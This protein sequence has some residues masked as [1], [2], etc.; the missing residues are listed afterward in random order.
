MSVAPKFRP[1]AA[2]GRPGEGPVSGSFEVVEHRRL[3][4]YRLLSLSAPEIATRARPGQFVQIAVA[5]PGTL[6]RRPFSIAAAADGGTVTVV[7]DVH[8]PGTEWLAGV[9]L[10]DHVEMI[11]PLGRGFPI[12]N[13]RVNT[14]LVAG[15]YGAAPLFWLAEALKSQGIRPDMINGAATEERLFGVIE[16]KRQ[17][18]SV[19]FTTDDG[20]FGTHGRVTDVLAERVEACST[21][22]VYAVGPMG[23]LR[24]V[25]E[26]CQRLEV[27]CQVAVEEQMACGVGVCWTC[28]IPIRDE[29]GTVHNRRSCLEGP[30]FNGA[31]IAWDETRW[32]VGPSVVPDD[33]EEPEPPVRPTDQELF[34]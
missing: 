34:G 1:G 12:P 10:H 17:T 7:Y 33:E 26:E 5:A 32:R 19:V 18:S 16:S 3:G 29:D 6:L 4:A 15:G 27:A 9:S 20:S 8:G 24:A 2:T 14:L 13:R 30:V 28:V 25:A 11:G 23:M 22:V 21:G 31:T